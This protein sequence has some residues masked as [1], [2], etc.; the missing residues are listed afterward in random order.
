[1]QIRQVRTKYCHSRAGGKQQFEDR[2]PQP[3]TDNLITADPDP[4]WEP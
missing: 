1:M 3:R 2:K 4:G